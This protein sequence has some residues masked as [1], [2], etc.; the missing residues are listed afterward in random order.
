MQLHLLRISILLM[1]LIYIFI[2]PAEPMFVKLV[3]KIIPMVLIIYYA[4]RQVPQ[5]REMTHSLLLIGLGFSMVGD[6]TLHWF[7]VGLS[8]FL[9]GH[10]CYIGAF[11]KQFQF[12]WQRATSLIPL[13]IFSA[14]IGSQ[15]V[16]GLKQSGN[17]ELIIPVIFY[18]LAIMMMCW[19]AM[20]TR[21]I[22]AMIGSIL[23]VISDSILAWNK[24]VAQVAYEDVLV[25]MTYYAAQ[26]FIAH[27]LMTIAQKKER[28]T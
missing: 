12:S 22:W 15:F 11:W 19:L 17:Q 2:V 8:A 26:F 16:D 18:I 25:M 9:I 4:C 21:N 14:M 5:H 13:L 20:M 27:S 23:F 28:T 1:V 3:F 6:G 10:L 24:F 7:I